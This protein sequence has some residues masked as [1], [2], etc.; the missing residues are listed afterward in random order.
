VAK[1][2]A[3]W[4]EVFKALGLGSTA[5]KKVIDHEIE[6]S[7]LSNKV[8]MTSAYGPKTSVPIPSGA[9]T[10]ALK[11]SLQP[12]SK[13][14]AS[15]KISSALNSLC[16]DIEPLMHDIDKPK[17]KAKV[18]KHMLIDASAMYQDAVPVIGYGPYTVTAIGDNVIFAVQYL[19]SGK[20]SFAFTGT[21]AGKYHEPLIGMGFKPMPMQD[22]TVWTMQVQVGK[23][24]LLARKTVGA[25]MFGLGPSMFHSPYPNLN[26]VLA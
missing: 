13:Q 9:V 16:K 22:H 2:K 7:F 5:I 10:M 17:K 15:Q 11:N 6:V 21:A 8:T 3:D 24:I 18:K 19:N 25:V 26:S 1:L 20:L 14:N 23:D 4:T 12:M